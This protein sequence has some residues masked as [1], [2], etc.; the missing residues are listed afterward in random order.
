MA[1][2]PEAVSELTLRRML[3][4]DIATRKIEGGDPAQGRNPFGLFD[5]YGGYIWLAGQGDVDTANEANAGVERFDPQTSKSTLLLSESALAGG[6]VIEV[7]VTAGCG[8]FI[9]A[10][11]SL[12]EPDRTR[13]ILARHGRRMT[14]AHPVRPDHRLR[15][16]RDVDQ[17]NVLLVEIAP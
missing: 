11:P 15:P 6:S 3:K 2:I 14:Y 16:A 1:D 17:G 13:H 10:D 8:A 4:I 12:E 5:I 7:A 9:V